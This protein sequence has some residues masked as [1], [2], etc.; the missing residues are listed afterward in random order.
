MRIDIPPDMREEMRNVGRRM[1]RRVTPAKVAPV[2]STLEYR[3]IGDADFQQLFL[4]VYDGAIM[5]NMKGTIVDANKRAVDFLKYARNELCGL[6]IPD[7]ISGAD[8]STVETLKTSLTTTRFVLMHAHCTRKDGY[9]F[10]AEIAINRV[11]VR[12]VEYLCC[13]IRDITW[14][15]HA[16]EMLRTINNAFQNSATGIAVSDDAG[17]IEYANTAVAR[18]WRVQDAEVL[19]GKT[20]AELL[21][22]PALA[23][24]LIEAVTQRRHWSGET[25][26]FPDDLMPVHIQIAA[27]AN[28]DSDNNLTGIVLSFLDITDAKRA[29]EAEKKAERQRVMVE[30]I[31]SAC[32]HLGQPATVLLT[33]LELMARAKPPCSDQFN[34]LLQSSVQAAESI[35][36]MLHNLNDISEYR[37]TTYIDAQPDSGYS[38]S[39]IVAFETASN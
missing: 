10:P 8:A 22:D 32:H 12:G 7:I 21:P 23:Q 13:F 35:R 38:A 1:R 34:E 11:Q 30:S 4:N 19:K 39:R 31:G 16:E 20:L 3:P 37:T 27:A 9:L 15:R 17:R 29:E 5:A 25:V 6:S 28:Q 18:L 33:S 36:E 14:R 26:L 2:D 24:T